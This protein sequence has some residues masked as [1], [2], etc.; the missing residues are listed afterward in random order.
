MRGA[1]ALKILEGDRVVL[2][3]GPGG[4]GKTTTSAAL[5]LAAALEGRKV[6]VLT[7]DPARRL[8]DALGIHLDNQPHRVDCSGIKEGPVQGEL[9]AM[10]LDPVKTFDELVAR[11]APTPKVAKRLT[12]N[13]IYQQMS[14]KLAGTLEY[15]A[16]EKLHELYTNSDFDLIIVDTPPSKNVLDFLESPEW[17]SR[18]M[19]ESVMK[20]FR[21]LD[22]LAERGGVRGTVMKTTGRLVSEVFDRLWGRELTR[23]F[24]DFMQGVTTMAEEFRL[25][26]DGV[27]AMLQSEDC[28][29]LVVAT[30]SELVM[31]DA[32]Y[33]A[34]EIQ[35][36]GIRFKGFILNRITEEVV[37]D[38]IDVAL[39]AVREAG[40]GSPA[41]EGL[42]EKL[43][44]L[45]EEN[46]QAVGQDRDAVT[47][48]RDSSAWG[49][50]L[51]LLPRQIGEVNDLP[52]LYGLALVL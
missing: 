31:R 39:G 48:L 11:I 49:G 51:G 41:L 10:M 9:W 37:S 32:S 46:V 13:V 18:F 21:R 23:H 27:S 3:A 45:A 19:D 29:F 43:K 25:R 1:G 33:L 34:T 15:M 52:S 7:I 42:L 24:T 50:F 6:C 20:W 38:G 30:T 44:K 22:P 26:G 12:D 47:R 36:R 40:T 8:A 5:G 17:I 14:R 35:R 16:V 2:C 28:S 4:V